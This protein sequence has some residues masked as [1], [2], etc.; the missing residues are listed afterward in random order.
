MTQKHDHK[1]NHCQHERL[2]YCAVCD[3][4]YCLDCG[5]EWVKQWVTWTYGTES[6]Q[7]LQ[8]TTITYAATTEAANTGCA[9][10]S[11]THQHNLGG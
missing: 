3:V 7:P 6:L 8:P 1:H 9:N 4:V 5:R 10:C 2:A 11:G